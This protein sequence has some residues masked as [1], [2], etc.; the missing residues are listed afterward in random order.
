[1]CLDASGKN[2]CH[3][4]LM[5]LADEICSDINTTSTTVRSHHSSLS[6][7]RHI[8]LYT[9][10]DTEFH[11]E[12]SSDPSTHR[13]RSVARRRS[14]ATEK[15]TFVQQCSTDG[16][17]ARAESS[18]TRDR[19]RRETESTTCLTTETSP[20]DKSG[21]R[22]TTDQIRATQGRRTSPG[23][24]RRRAVLRRITSDLICM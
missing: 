17:R 13:D 14:Q 20:P 2:H 3:L 9:S 6:L 18:R 4:C 12:L 15:I 1:M 24:S 10:S 16:S 19:C 21:E 7:F 23:Q 22:T 8:Y 5:C 11:H